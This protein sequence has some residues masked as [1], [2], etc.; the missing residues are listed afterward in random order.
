MVFMINPPTSVYTGGWEGLQR[1]LRAEC[2]KGQPALNLARLLA[3]LVVLLFRQLES[4]ISFDFYAKGNE[5]E[6]AKPK[7]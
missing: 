4:S 7:L 5:T 6:N 3:G 2:V 1:M